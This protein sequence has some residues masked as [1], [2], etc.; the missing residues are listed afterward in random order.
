M[1]AKMTKQT[2]QYTDA[3][4][5]QIEDVDHSGAYWALADIYDKAPNAFGPWEDEVD[6]D[7]DVEDPNAHVFT[8]ED[9]LARLAVTVSH[10]SEDD[11]EPGD[12]TAPGWYWAED[13]GEDEDEDDEDPPA[14]GGPFPSAQD[15]RVACDA[16]LKAEGCYLARPLDA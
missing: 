9:G 12:E 10:V 7:G 5:H 1:A 16:F 6:E 3:L 15:A 14:S 4:L 13:I 2:R 8:R 11:R